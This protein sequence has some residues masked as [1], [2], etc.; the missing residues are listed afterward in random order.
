[1]PKWETCVEKDGTTYCWD[2]ETNSY[3]SF[4]IKKKTCTLVPADVANKITSL[5]IERI[6]KEKT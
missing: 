4:E 6:K 2:D 3:I 1:M 5:I